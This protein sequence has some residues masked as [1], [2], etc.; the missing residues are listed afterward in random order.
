MRPEEVRSGERSSS[1]SKMTADSR[2]LR[3]GSEAQ[4]RRFD[5]ATAMDCGRA[6]EEYSCPGP[7]LRVE[8]STRGNGKGSRKGS[9]LASDTL[10]LGYG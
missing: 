2:G 10:L 9:E 6:T 1:R 4:R 8:V 3:Q 7:R 5:S